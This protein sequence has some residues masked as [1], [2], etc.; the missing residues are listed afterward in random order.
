M[1]DLLVLLPGIR[2]GVTVGGVVVLLAVVMVLAP[3][4]FIMLGIA[5][6]VPRIIG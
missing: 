6:I 5:I 1:I 3:V 4:I 2:L